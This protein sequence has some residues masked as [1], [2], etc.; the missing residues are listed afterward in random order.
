[1]R[2]LSGAAVPNCLVLLAWYDDDDAAAAATGS[3][4][5]CLVGEQ[6]RARKRDTGGWK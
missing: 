1:M 5:A 2:L 3:G 4:L 6:G